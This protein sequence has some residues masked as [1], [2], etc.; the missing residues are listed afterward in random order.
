[1]TARHQ[2]GKLVR[3]RIPEIIRAAG[4]EPET[5]ALS[6]ADYVRALR[7]KVFEEVNELLAADAG[8]MAEEAADVLEVIQALVRTSNVAWADVERI[9]HRK[10]E[11]RGAFNNRVWL[12][13]WYQEEEIP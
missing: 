10:Q 1:M 7:A 2:G 3:D 9:Q 5:W 12:E 11:E 13:S 4:G 6:E 8:G